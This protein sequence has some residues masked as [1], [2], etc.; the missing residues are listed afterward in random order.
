MPNSPT[1]DPTAIFCRCRSSR[2]AS[3]R[4][5]FFDPGVLRIVRG[6]MDDQWGC[7]TPVRGSET[8]NAHIDYQRPRFAEAPELCEFSARLRSS[9]GNVVG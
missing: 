8:Q 2:P 9:V 5:F 6:V 4:I 3:L 1:V 7:D